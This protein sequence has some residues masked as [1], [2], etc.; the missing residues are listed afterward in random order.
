MVD[1]SG[2][3]DGVGCR[4]AMVVVLYGSGEGWW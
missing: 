4:V 3:G 1:G 2:G